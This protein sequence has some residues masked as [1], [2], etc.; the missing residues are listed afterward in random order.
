MMR[1]RAHH[2]I[3]L[4]ALASAASVVVCPEH[5]THVSSGSSEGPVEGRTNFLK[6]E[7]QDGG[8]AKPSVG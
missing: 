1:R 2:C 8:H 4:F 6:N 5:V 3:V 7:R